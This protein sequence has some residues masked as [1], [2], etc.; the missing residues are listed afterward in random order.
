MMAATTAATMA[1]S[2]AK[3]NRSIERGFSMPI[4]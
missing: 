2:I 3:M 4:F 1:T